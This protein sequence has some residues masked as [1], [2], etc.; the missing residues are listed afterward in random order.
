MNGKVVA[1]AMMGDSGRISELEV[2][3]LTSAGRRPGREG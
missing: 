1:V 3:P 2:E